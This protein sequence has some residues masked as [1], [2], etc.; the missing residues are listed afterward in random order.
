MKKILTLLLCALIMISPAAYAAVPLSV[1]VVFDAENEDVLLSGKGTSGDVIITVT[2]YGDNTALSESHHPLDII[3]VRSTGT[4]GTTLELAGTSAAGKKLTVTAF[5]AVGSSASID[6]VNPDFSAATKLMT[7]L[8]AASDVNAFMAIAEP[9][10][11]ILGFDKDSQI[12]QT[13]KRKIYSVLY[14]ILPD[15]PTPAKVYNLYYTACALASLNG[16]TQAQAE[17][18]LESNAPYIGI[19]YDAAYASDSRLNSA[20][21]TALCTIL[22]TE[23]F[24]SVLSS[25]ETFAQY[26]EKAKALASVKAA[27]NW[28]DIK[29]VIETNFS[30]LFTLSSVSASAAQ[31]IYGKMM[32]YQYNKFSDIASNYTL[33]LT[34]VQ[35]ETQTGNTSSNRG[36]SSGGGGSVSLPPSL[37]IEIDET[38]TDTSANVKTPMVTLPA[39]ASSNFYDVPASHWSYDA[40]SALSTAGIISGYDA[41][42]FLPSNNITRAEFTKLVC[43]SFGIPTANAD[44]VDVAADSWYNGYVGGASS[45]GIVGGYGDTF[46]PNDSITRQDAAVIVYRA[47]KNEDIILSGTADFTDK[48]DI[49]LYALTAV[50]AF[51]EYGILSGDGTN[52]RPLANITRAEAAQL[53]YKALSV[54]SN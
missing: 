1:S 4:Y 18:I 20:S 32:N 13:A 33:A 11:A 25:S 38:T 14:A 19:D 54:G 2:E 27:Q 24:G 16:A 49:S 45:Y 9:N 26:F 8:A 43:A 17:Q 39:D 31:K 37:N 5:D 21:K 41:V 10:A 44:F 36:G 12:Y 22:A 51:K 52:F 30:S 42:T 46:G 23:D 40:V 47:L 35:S 15:N 7:S 28:Q 48:M 29:N 53:L 3:S 6:F 50:G 34:A